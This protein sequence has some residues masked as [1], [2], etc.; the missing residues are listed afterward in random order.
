MFRLARASCAL[1]FSLFLISGCTPS[2]VVV[3]SSK[4][5][6]NIETDDINIVLGE[7]A[8]VNADTEHS[9]SPSH[10]A[11]EEETTRLMTKELK[12]QNVMMTFTEMPS[13]EERERMSIG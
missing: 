8:P 2:Q 1:I 11:L 12:H 4:E 13:P 3:T 9:S 6:L 5:P 7:E 10:K